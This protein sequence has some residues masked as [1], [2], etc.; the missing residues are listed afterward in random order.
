MKCTSC[1]KSLP[2]EAFAWKLVDKRRHA[3]C[4]SCHARYTKKHYADNKDAYL[5]RSRKSNP[6]YAKA[7]KEWV[8]SLKDNKPCLDCGVAY[9]WWIM[10]F[11]HVRG[12]KFRSISEMCQRVFAKSTIASEIAKC[13]LVCSNCHQNRTFL[14]RSGGMEDTPASKSGG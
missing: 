3:K 11:D 1:R 2:E 12:K 8:A 9:R 13:D 5:A 7:L 10:E 4:R 14:R 6:R